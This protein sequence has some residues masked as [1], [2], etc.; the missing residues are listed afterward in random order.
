M[1]GQVLD[2]VSV[3]TTDAHRMVANIASF[4]RFAADWQAAHTQG[5]LGDFVAYLD[6]YQEAGGELPTSV[7]L[8]EDVEGV[9]LMT[10]YQAKGLEFP[11]VFVPALLEDEW[12]TRVGWSGFFPQELLR[13][14]MPGEDIHT[15]EERRLLYV[16]MTRAQE[17]LMLTTHG[18][19]AVAKA[20]S[21]F[22]AEIRDGAS[23]ELTVVDRTDTSEDEGEVGVEPVADPTLTL[24]RRV[25]AQPSKR[26]RRLAL[27]LRATEL[28]GLMEGTD[29]TDPEASDARAA[30]AH[31]LAAVGQAAV[32][33][34]DAAR[35]AGLDPLT[36]RVIAL[37]SGAGANLLDVAALPEKFSYSSYSTYEA[38]PLRY[39]FSY[40]YRIP[41][42]DKPVAAFAFGSTAHEAFEAFTRERRERL[43]RGEDPPT[44]DDLER[45]F[46]ERWTP[47]AFGDRTT[48]EAYGRRVNTLLENFWNGEVSSIGQAI[49]EEQ[50]FDLV[51]EDPGGGTPVIVSGSIDRIDR[52][53]SGQVEVI[54]YKT[55]RTSSQKGVD[56]SLQLSIYALACRDALGL[57][58]PEKV[59]LYFTESAT[60][61]STTRTDEQLDAVRADIL[62]RTARI[63]SGDFAATPSPDTCR[64]CDY[65][66]LCPS[67]GVRRNRLGSRSLDRVRRLG[68]LPELAAQVG[69][70]RLC[71]AGSRRRSPLRSATISPASA[72]RIALNRSARTA[73]HPSL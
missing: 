8:T 42:P 49:A 11:Y 71:R 13:E 38:C 6:A 55:G 12:P 17:R 60:R 35:A 50:T 73:G 52:L 41:A 20:A 48:E 66:R 45:L 33:D 28:V 21:L 37:D 1:T 61:M 39:A 5:T 58:T 18:G 23:V 25:M 65:A 47:I 24:L 44:R 32:M 16:A 2:L 51:I 26:E 57:G 63:R 36:L 40:L 19:A 67:R 10:L 30:L 7:E 31:D 29:A 34:A 46:R 43:A 68:T 27:R 56:E 3:G 59:T 9:R 22:I 14:P 69:A 4:M 70:D 62:A 54:D 53:P 15:E 72:P 64:W